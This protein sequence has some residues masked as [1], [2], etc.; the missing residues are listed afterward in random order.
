MLRHLYG[1]RI[2]LVGWLRRIIERLHRRLLRRF[3]DMIRAS[4]RANSGARDFAIAIQD[5]STYASIHRQT[6]KN[7]RTASTYSTGCRSK[8][9][10]PV[11]DRPAVPAVFLKLPKSC[12][13]TPRS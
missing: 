6:H 13:F 9:V 10:A 11:M 4:M 1:A 2:I 3:L 12:L 5:I 7:P 8:R